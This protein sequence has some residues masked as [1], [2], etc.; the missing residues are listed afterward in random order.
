MTTIEIKK[1]KV[2]TV[3]DSAKI[4]QHLS[5]L[6]GEINYVDRIG[7]AYT[8]ENAHKHIHKNKPD[9]VILDIQLKEES[10]L[11]LLTHLHKNNPEII[12]MMLSNMSYPAY[13]I[14]CLELGAKYF[15][16]KSIDF[17]KI[18]IVIETIYKDLFPL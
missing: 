12:V 6:L 7:H 17:E 1:L 2:L 13:R 15:L 4:A 9:V 10:G 5:Q 8:L 11:D 16:D 14:K 18:P 3:D